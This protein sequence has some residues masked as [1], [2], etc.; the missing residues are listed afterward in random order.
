[1]DTA[2]IL[3]K[4]YLFAALPLILLV[5]LVEYAFQPGTMLNVMLKRTVLVGSGEFFLHERGG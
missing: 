1:M 4:Y 3:K 5:M 2:K